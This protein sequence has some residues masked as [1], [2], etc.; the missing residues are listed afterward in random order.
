MKTPK[1]MMAEAAPPSPE[2]E[3]LHG[4]REG[5]REVAPGIEEDRR[6]VAYLAGTT[7]KVTEVVLNQAWTG[8]TTEKLQ[9]GMSHLSLAQV[10]AA[11]AYYHAHRAKCDEQI[12]RGRRFAERLEAKAGESPLARRL[13]GAG[14]PR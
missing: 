1:T 11:L 10:E 14:T 7:T 12:E 4:A 13:R 3:W 5:L 8:D 2:E 6:G 9:E